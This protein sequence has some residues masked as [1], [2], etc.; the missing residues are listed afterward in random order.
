M[1]ARVAD[2]GVRPP[3]PV[4]D[5]VSGIVVV[6]VVVVVVVVVVLVDVVLAAERAVNC[7]RA[8]ETE[9]PPPRPESERT[10]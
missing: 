5:V 8:S 4:L 3:A 9:R 7:R 1:L 2:D 6:N 10:L